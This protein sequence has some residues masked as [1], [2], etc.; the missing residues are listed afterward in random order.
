VPSQS[1][2]ALFRSIRKGEIPG[3]IYL[4]GPEDLLK[5]EL[6]ADLTSRVL[7]PGTREFNLDLRSAATLDADDVEALCTTLPMMADRRVV[8]IR[9]VEVWNKRARAKTAVLAYLDRPS[10]ETVLVLVQG[11]AEPAADA[12]LAARTTHAAAEPLSPDRA[13]KWLILQAGRRGLELD[14]AAADHLVRVTD[15]DLAALKTELDKLAGL[16]GAEPLSLERVSAVLGVRRGETQYDWREAVLAGQAGRAAALL[17]HILGQTGVSG[18]SLVSLLGT[19]L[20]GLGLARS[21]YDRGARGSSLARA[22]TDVLFRVR[23]SRLSYRAAA[24]EWS[25]LVSDWPPAR[26]DNAI[27]AA[28]RADERLKT[29][30][31]SDERAILFDLVMELARPW[32]AAA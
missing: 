16:A 28:L 12:E 30:S 15:G 17:P 1:F 24:D 2:D 23:P 13:G 14:P 10:P 6:I 26:I 3:A 21:L 25:R 9:D 5:D 32:K 29:T 22:I 8:V 19:S 11:G 18:V 20:V 7:D 27:R 31:V 4:H